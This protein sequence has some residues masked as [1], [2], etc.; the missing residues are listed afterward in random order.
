MA[1]C[2]QLSLKGQGQGQEQR[3][4]RDVSR[5]NRSASQGGPKQGGQPPGA[6]CAQE[7]IVSTGEVEATQKYLAREHDLKTGRAWTDQTGADI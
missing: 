7:P 1:E 6:C 5:D 4:E 2:S 3:E